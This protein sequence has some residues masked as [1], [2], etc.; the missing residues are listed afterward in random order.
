MLP[1]MTPHS[2]FG[3]QLT[4]DDWVRAGFAA[5]TDGGADALRIGRLCAR[6]GV[7]K[8]SFYWH[9]SDMA[10]YR[11]A[12]AGAWSTLNDERRLRIESIGETDSDKRLAALITELLDPEHFALER[13][14][15][16]W[17]LKDDTVATSVARCD[18]RVH[19]LVR[20]VLIEHGLDEAAAD[21]RAALVCAARIGL[22]FDTAPDATPPLRERLVDFM[23]RR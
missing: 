5:L 7:T 16:V 10:E 18:R 17:A 19:R 23:V 8:G 11:A 14:M 12:L 6:L 9:F 15:R 4:A 21:E 3:R 22:L 20:Q 1:I 2:G 13:A